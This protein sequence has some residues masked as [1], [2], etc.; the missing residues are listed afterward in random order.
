ML[1]GIPYGSL[2]TT[3]ATYSKLV[4]YF[5]S[6]DL[7]ISPSKSSALQDMGHCISVSPLGG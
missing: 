4:C 3:E 2:S 7:L 5:I 1:Y 6:I